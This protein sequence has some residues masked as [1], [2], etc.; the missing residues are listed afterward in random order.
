MGQV[1]SGRRLVAWGLLC[2]GDYQ[3]R[4]ALDRVERRA[5]ARQAPVYTLPPRMFPEVA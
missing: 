2:L 4:F 1:M 3:L 5:P